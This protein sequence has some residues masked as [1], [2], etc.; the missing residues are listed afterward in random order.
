MPVAAGRPIVTPRRAA[1]MSR[2]FASADATQ[3]SDGISAGRVSVRIFS[4]CRV[5]FGVIFDPFVEV[6][7]EK[8]LT[9][10]KCNIN[11]R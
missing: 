2:G 5:F 4:M 1:A 8:S 3:F 7:I 6:V 9:N 11:R 10:R